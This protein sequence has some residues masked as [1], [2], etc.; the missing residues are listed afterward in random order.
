MSLLSEIKTTNG[1]SHMLELVKKI[2]PSTTA[3]GV[4]LPP[5][6]TEQVVSAP[7]TGSAYELQDERLPS[8]SSF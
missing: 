3:L 1:S 6:G 8:V 7:A 2:N 4:P 5:R